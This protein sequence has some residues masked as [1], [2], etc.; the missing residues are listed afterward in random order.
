VEGGGVRLPELDVTATGVHADLQTIRSGQ[1]QA[2]ADRVTGT[3]TVGYA[4]VAALTNQPGLELSA[5]NGE[6]RVRAPVQLLGQEVTLVGT[7]DVRV[8]DNLVRVAVSELDAEDGNLPARARE[9]ADQYAE[10]LSVSFELPRLPF[11]LTLGE[12]TPQPAGLTVTA[13]ASGVPITS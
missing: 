1:G 13:S 2:M 3:A 7:A 9:L 5:E 4:T 8:D 11:D 12:V 10:R 6:L